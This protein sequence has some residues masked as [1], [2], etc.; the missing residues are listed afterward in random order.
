M[1]LFS[2]FIKENEENNG[3]DF[4]KFPAEIQNQFIEKSMN[5]FE[6]MMRKYPSDCMD[7][8]NKF[9]D[10]DEFIKSEMVS[11][12]TLGSAFSGNPKEYGLG[13][14][15]GNYPKTGMNN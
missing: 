11:M 7:F 13:Y 10:K 9:T 4:A 1:K 14:L 5:I 12:K 2:Q 6:Y 3:V 15:K 8:I